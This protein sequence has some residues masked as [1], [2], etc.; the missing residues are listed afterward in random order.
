VALVTKFY[1]ENIKRKMV[2]QQSESLQ[3]KIFAS[4]SLDRGQIPRIYKG[5]KNVRNKSTNNPVNKWAS[6]LNR[7]FSK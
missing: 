2:P 7:H 1:P 4:H 6:D 3:G 5:L